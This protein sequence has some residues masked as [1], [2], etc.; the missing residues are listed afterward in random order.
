MTRSQKGNAT[1]MRLNLFT[2][3]NLQQSEILTGNFR[4]PEMLIYIATIRDSSSFKNA[5]IF[6][7]YV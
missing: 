2:Q 6:M 5:T 4:R 1:D 3:K 7:A